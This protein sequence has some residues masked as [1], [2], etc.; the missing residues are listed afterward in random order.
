MDEHTIDDI[1]LRSGVLVFLKE[2]GGTEKQIHEYINGARI[3]EGGIPGE[4]LAREL[5]A[6]EADGLLTTGDG[7]AA[8]GSVLY[9]ATPRGRQYLSAAMSRLRR[10]YAVIHTLM[11]RYEEAALSGVQ[12]ELEKKRSEWRNVRDKK[13]GRKEE[14]LARGMDKKAIKKEP[15][16]KDLQKEQHHLS[17]V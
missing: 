15:V 10:H 4:A 6:M 7:S 5:G 13:L 16:Y 14:L 11:S 9:R 1:I 2:G 3:R 17:T 8:E 12:A